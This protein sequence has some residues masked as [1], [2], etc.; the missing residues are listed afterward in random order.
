MKLRQFS[1][2][3]VLLLCISNGG[4]AQEEI[5]GLTT[6]SPTGTYYQIGKDIRDT[7][8][9]VMNIEVHTSGGSL[10]NLDRILKERGYQFAI[11]QYDAL[12]YRELSNPDFGNL[13]KMIF[14]L[15]NEEIHILVNLNSGI[16]G[17]LDLQGKRVN[18]DRE[19]SGTWV[20]ANVI[21]SYLEL[22]WREQHFPPAEALEQ[23]LAGQIDA[24]IY[25]VGQPAH[26]F[27]VLSDKAE[28]HIKLLSYENPD[29]D[30]SFIKTTIKSGTYPWQKE[31]AKVY[32]VKSVLVTY[33]YHDSGDVPPRFKHYVKK[34]YEMIKEITDNLENLKQY[35]HPKWKEIDPRDLTKVSWPVHP[36]VVEAL[37]DRDPLKSKITDADVIDIIDKLRKDLEKSR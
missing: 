4:N 26:L 6:G 2:C 13:I 19:N 36:K 11:V 30:E 23:L 24:M 28:N 9:D 15:Y 5:I 22:D 35:S 34:I 21:E 17:I 27:E 16:E 7:C 20:T 25:T 10:V 31:T 14:P 29:L 33:N 18:V 32:A 1:I 12:L 37:E 8:K 3:F